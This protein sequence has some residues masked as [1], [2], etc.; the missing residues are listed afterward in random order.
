MSSG[1]T[2][3]CG[4]ACIS[5]R[6]VRPNRLKSFTYSPPRNVCKA[7]YTSVTGTPSVCALSVSRSTRNCGTVVR[8]PVLIEAISGR[9]LADWTNAWVTSESPCR[10]PTG[11]VREHHLDPACGAQSEDWRQPESE[12]DAALELR[13]LRLHLV[14]DR[15]LI[16]MHGR[17]LVPRFQQGDHRRDRR[18]DGVRQAIEA[19]KRRDRFDARIGAQDVLNLADDAIG[20]LDR[21][22]VGQPDG[23]E[24][25]ALIFVGQESRRRLPEE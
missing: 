19:A 10:L 16:E 20:A 13:Q 7:E 15:L 2:P 25:D 17:T 6:Q 18:V 12:D 23:D 5:T 22:A 21:G 1:R 14:Q 8:K 11:W 4:S 3:K 24:E 9:C